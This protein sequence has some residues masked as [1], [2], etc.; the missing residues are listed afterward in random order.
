MAAGYDSAVSI[1]FPFRPWVRRTCR[2]ATIWGVGVLALLG[3]LAWLFR[4]PESEPLSRA[5]GALVAYGLLF[6]VSLAKIWWTAG[7]AAVEL[8]DES[9][10]YQP[11]HTFRPRRIA[12]DSVMAAAPKAGTQSL[13]LVYEAKPGRGREFFLN[14][15]VIDGRSA[16]LAGL[17]E[18]LASRGLER[19]PGT[20]HSWRRPGWSERPPDDSR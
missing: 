16:F 19:D 6:L 1:S 5:F 4:A 14:L 18:Q 17:G 2:R 13:R 11:L 7:D 15:G 20:A 3:A 10:A 9:L 8:D 12:L